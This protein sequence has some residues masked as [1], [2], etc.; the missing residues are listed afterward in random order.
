MTVNVTVMN[1]SPGGGTSAVATFTVNNPVPAVTAVSPGS[2]LAGS[3]DATL[4]LTGTGFVSSS[5][6]NWN[7]TPLTTTFVSGTE[8]KATLPLDGPG[9]RVRIANHGDES[10]TGGRQLASGRV[11]CE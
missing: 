1:P 2:A 5:V 6:V 11:Q 7:G 10:S 3:G 4:D 8:L 9:G